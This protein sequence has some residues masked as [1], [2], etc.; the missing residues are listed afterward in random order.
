VAKP[1]EAEPL[2]SP[3]AREYGDL[4]AIIQDLEFATRALRRAIPLIPDNSDD[5]SLLAEALWTAAVVTYARC[6]G[7]GRRTRLVDDAL[8]AATAQEREL[9]TK[10]IEQRNTH[11]AHVVSKLEWSDVYLATTPDGVRHVFA[12]S[13]R[14]TAGTPEEATRLVDLIGVVRKRVEA[15]IE[16]LLFEMTT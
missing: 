16:E 10:V 12:L 3:K 13:D 7:S 2:K 8:A 9:H 4:F 11:L 5:A 1:L 14:L 15:R 6:F